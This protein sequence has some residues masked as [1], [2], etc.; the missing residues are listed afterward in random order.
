MSKTIENNQI[1]EL[2]KVQFKSKDLPLGIRLR[3][4]GYGFNLEHQ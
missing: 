1:E 2:Q 4:I 3:V